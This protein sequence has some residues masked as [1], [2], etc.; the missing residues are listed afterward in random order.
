M[1]FLILLYPADFR[2]RFESELLAAS[3]D[4]G[5]REA[6]GLLFG[7]AR[8]WVAKW[9]TPDWIRARWV[10]D[11]RWIRPAGVSREEYFGRE[12]VDLAD[13]RREVAFCQASGRGLRQARE[14][15][16]RVREKYGIA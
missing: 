7:A 13:A 12:P 3:Q 5:W 4:G 11:W 15:L 16:A 14:R 9:T 1:R 8:E 2:A 10:R 6:A